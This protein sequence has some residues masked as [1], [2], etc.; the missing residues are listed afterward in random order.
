MHRRYRVTDSP[1]GDGHHEGVEPQPSDL[2]VY[3]GARGS[4]ATIINPPGKPDWAMVF[5]VHATTIFNFTRNGR[6]R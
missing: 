4:Y 5:H 2:S 6:S 1:Q 3:F